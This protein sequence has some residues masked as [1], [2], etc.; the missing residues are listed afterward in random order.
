DLSLTGDLAGF[1]KELAVAQKESEETRARLRLLEAGSRP[2]EIEG[3]EATLARLVSQRSHLEAQLRLG[4]G[5]SPI[6]GV[7]AKAK[8][9]EKGGQYMRK[10]DL[11][12]EVHEFATVRVEI[13]VP[14]REIGDVKVGQPV[15]VKARAFP[16]HPS[17]GRVT[18]IAPVAVKDE[19]AWRGKVFRVT[20]AVDNPDLRLRSDMTGTAKIYCGQ[21]R[22][23]DVLSRRLARYARVEFWSWW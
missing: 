11:L 12:V 6:D 3:A 7:V 13:A 15:I 20:T 19:E 22:L 1:R 4:M 14:E 8:P 23:F 16:E 9:R 5:L 10:G 2:E 18:A 17:E 21:R